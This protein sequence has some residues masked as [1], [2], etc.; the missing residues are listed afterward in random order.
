MLTAGPSQH[1]PYQGFEDV[2]HDFDEV[3]RVDD[4]QSFQVFL[5][6]V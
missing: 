4:I 3:R 6:P 5:V 2:P 1:I